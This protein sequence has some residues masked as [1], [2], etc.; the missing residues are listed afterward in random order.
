MSLRDRVTRLERYTRCVNEA[1]YVVELLPGETPEQAIAR[2]K[3]T[4]PFALLPAQIE[5]MEEW[6]QEARRCL[7]GDE[8]VGACEGPYR[9]GVKEPRYDN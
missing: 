4:G 7:R 3:P 8:K 6:A 9:W 2:A 5:S 1:C